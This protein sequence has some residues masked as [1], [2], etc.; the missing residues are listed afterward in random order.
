VGNILFHL[1][2]PAPELPKQIILDSFFESL[3]GWDVYTTGVAKAYID[4]EYIALSTQAQAG[5]VAGII[6]RLAYPRSPLTWNKPR[7]FKCKA[8]VDVASDSSSLIYINTGNEGSNRRGFGFRFTNNKVRG[9]SKNGG[10][11]NYVDL[12]TGLTAPYSREEVYEAVFTPGS[13]IDF[14]I[15]GVL[16]GT[17][18]SGLPTGTSDA[19]YLARLLVYASVAVT[20]EIKTSM[21]RAIQDE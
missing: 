9:F 8:R 4:S 17:L 16:M 10:A 15:D 2:F 3:D 18:T 19:H 21:F 13:K 1:Q 7:S 14:Y 11:E 12:V 6:K 5:A 20:H